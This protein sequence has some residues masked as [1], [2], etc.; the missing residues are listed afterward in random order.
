MAWCL[1]FHA[2]YRCRHAG[3]CC[4]AA[5]AIPFEDGTVAAR[6]AH[7]ACSFFDAA[8]SLCL[9]HGAHGIQALP[10]TCRMFPRVV[11]HDCRGS[12]ISLSHFCPTAARLLFEASGDAAIVEAPPALAA[13]GELDGLDARR[14]WPPLLRPGVLMDPLSYGEWERRAL[15]LLTRSGGSGQDA[16]AALEATTAPIAAWTPGN[17]ALLDAVHRAF[18]EAPSCAG[19][20]PEGDETAV[21]RWLAARLFGAWTAYQGDGLT[22]TLRYL[23]GCLDTF[24]RERAADGDAFEAIRRSDLRIVHGSAPIDLSLNR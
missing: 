22:A 19:E 23:C 10:V 8:T 20:R 9:I 14:E 13:V 21:R 7:G 5:W 1:D 15:L 3:A 17:G 18:D 12:F 16:L 4:T 6:D 24:T 2:S 11:L